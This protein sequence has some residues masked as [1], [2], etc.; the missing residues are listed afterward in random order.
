MKNVI[1]TL[2]LACSGFVLFA[3]SPVGKW[4]TYDDNT[5][6]NKS[7]IEIYKVGTKL[8]GKVLII[9]DKAKADKTCELCSDDRKNK[10]VQGMLIIKGL[11]E[12]GKEWSD[13]EILDPENGK[14]YDCTIWLESNDVLKVR[15][16]IGWF[17][18]TQT[19]KRVK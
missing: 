3:Q 11:G 5:G 13:G 6:E 9:H 18:R 14:T 15:G 10:P 19:W 17:Y 4:N 7:V 12:D 1:L 16:Y 2:V 8:Y